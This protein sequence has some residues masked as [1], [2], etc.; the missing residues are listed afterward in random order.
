MRIAVIAA[1]GR[2]GRAFVMAALKAGHHVRA[3]VHGAASFPPYDRLEVMPCDATKAAEVRRLLDDQ[4]AVV[5]LIGHTKGSAPDVQTAAIRHVVRAMSELGIE[6]LVSLTGTGVRLAGDKP[7]IMDRLL[8]LAVSMVDPARVRDGREHAELL[9]ASNLAWTVIRVLKLQN[10]PSQP[11]MLTL[12]GPTK[13]YVGR[14][15]VAAAILQVLEQQSFVRA[16]PIISPT[17]R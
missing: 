4:E 2:S 17:G 9:K 14:D 6:R 12:H 16:M 5:S 1:G 10:V 7:T 8:N 3:G 15:E 13:L 11:F